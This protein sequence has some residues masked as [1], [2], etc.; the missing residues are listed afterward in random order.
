MRDLWAFLRVRKKWWLA[1]VIF[2]LVLL[3]VLSFTANHNVF[4]QVFLY[5]F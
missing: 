1:P 3:G 5:P 2:S 4:A